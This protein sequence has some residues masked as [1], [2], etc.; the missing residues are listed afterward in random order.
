MIRLK[1][2]ALFVVALSLLVPQAGCTAPHITGH[3]D[4]TLNV[5][6]LG[7]LHVT[8]DVDSAGTQVFKVTN[9]T[10]QPVWVQPRDS[11][12]N[13]IGP[14]IEVPPGGSVKLPP[15]ADSD[16]TGVVKK[17]EPPKPPDPK[18]VDPKPETITQLSRKL[19]AEPDAVVVLPLQSWPGINTS[20]PASG[21]SRVSEY[22]IAA[23]DASGALDAL[24]KLDKG[25]AAP[26]AELVAR[27][28]L[29]P[30][31]STTAQFTTT[32]ASNKI[33][34]FEVY[35]NGVVVASSVTGLGGAT[36]VYSS[37]GYGT[38]TASI[39]FSVGSTSNAV[40]WVTTDNLGVQ[41]SRSYNFH[42]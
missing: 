24:A 10:D 26:N 39:L 27:T 1:L 28:E 5:P 40:E 3:L 14:P 23:R 7:S 13:P 22:R 37:D 29:L 20:F 32:M 31:S 36:I 6:G 11:D 4:G 41:T 8:L 12:G 34:Q 33:A 18:P 30:T 19:H 38:G 35:V 9:P 15:G 42:L 17:P 16:T 25:L 21:Q 2:L